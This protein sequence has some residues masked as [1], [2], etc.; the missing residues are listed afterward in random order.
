MRFIC[1]AQFDAP[2]S[3]GLAFLMA[4]RRRFI[5]PV[6]TFLAIAA[7][8]GCAIPF[9]EAGGRTHYLIVG[10]GLASTTP[11]PES[12]TMV[13]RATTL[14]LTL[15]DQPGTRFAVGY[16]ESFVTSIDPAAGNM[17]VEVLAPNFG[18]VEIHAT[19]GADQSFAPETKNVTKEVE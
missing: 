17:V 10:I 3:M 13:T 5:R 2:P 6:I 4:D 12:A 9:H 18:A 16:A 14:G 1:L 11:P 15:S 19:Q 8:S 7:L